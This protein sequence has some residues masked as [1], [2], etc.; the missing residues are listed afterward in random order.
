[1]PN[2]KTVHR[3]GTVGIETLARRSVR[4]SLRESH[5]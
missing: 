3:L 1:M 2:A 5:A 4:V